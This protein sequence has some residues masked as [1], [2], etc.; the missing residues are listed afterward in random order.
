[1]RRCGRVG[2]RRVWLAGALLALLPAIPA[3]AAELRGR[4]TAVTGQDVRIEVE[5]DLLPRIGD[6]VRLSFRIPGGPEVMVGQWRVSAVDAGGVQ[7]TIVQ[8]SGAPT[9]GQSATIESANPTSRSALSPAPAG[10]KPNVPAL[11]G[12]GPS[13]LQPLGPRRNITR[14]PLVVGPLPIGNGRAEQVGPAYVIVSSAGLTTWKPIS[15]EP[16]SKLLATV[17][18]R[19]QRGSSDPAVT[20][21]LLSAAAGGDFQEGDLFFGK[22]DDDGPIVQRWDGGR[23]TRIPMLAFRG[24]RVTAAAVDRFEVS[25]FG[26]RYELRINGELVGY[27]DDPE[28]RSQWVHV[29]A[30][31]GNRAEFLDWGVSRLE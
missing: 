6:A 21:L 26:G 2:A 11:G 28:E 14:S 1:M 12:P 8:A 5:G 3:V 29:Y 25:K 18:A 15:R 7:A 22:A 31:V 27:V 16:A 4:V 17:R 10:P 30:G 20:G 9:V 13:A 23:W 19:V 24:G